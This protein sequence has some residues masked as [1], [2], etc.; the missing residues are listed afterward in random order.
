MNKMQLFLLPYLLTSASTLRRGC[1]NTFLNTLLNFHYPTIPF[2]KR[3][4]ESNMQW[5]EMRQENIE[6]LQQ[7]Q[8][9]SSKLQEINYSQKWPLE[10]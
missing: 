4:V 9:C 8:D 1:G 5:H 2:Y 3:A 10:L 7:I 6:V